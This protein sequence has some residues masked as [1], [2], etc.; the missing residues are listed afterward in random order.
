MLQVNGHNFV[1]SF[2]DSA[3]P[4]S[5]GISPGRR[6]RKKLPKQRQTTENSHE[7][8]P[9]ASERSKTKEAPKPDSGNERKPGKI[10]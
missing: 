3:P 9:S 10:K 8:N 4:P 7:N 2:Q 5:T 6:G 1:N